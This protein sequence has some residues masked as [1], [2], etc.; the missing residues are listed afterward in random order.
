MA[1]SNNRELLDHALTAA[2]PPLAVFVFELFFPHPAERIS[3]KLLW[4]LIAL[5]VVTFVFVYFMSQLLEVIRSYFPA[6]LPDIGRIDG[7]WIDVVRDLGEEILG[8]GTVHFQTN[9]NGFTIKGWFYVP[10][11]REGLVEVGWF[12]G[13]GFAVSGD[14]IGYYF[15]GQL[16]DQENGGSGHFTF[17]PAVPPRHNCIVMHGFFMGIKTLSE[18]GPAH[19][20]TGKRV[21]GNGTHEAAKLMLQGELRN[22]APRKPARESHGE[23][24]SV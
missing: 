24:R 10:N 12:L 13:S 9:G 16:N 4:A 17:T 6:K 15:K 2:L 22:N 21:E 14:T 11:E 19:H 1:H 5:Y 3:L 18:R 8:G 23:L 20:F 7:W